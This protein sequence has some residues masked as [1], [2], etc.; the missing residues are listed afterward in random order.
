MPVPEGKLRS[1]FE[2]QLV[3]HQ[4]RILGCLIQLARSQNTRDHIPHP[5]WSNKGLVTGRAI[6]SENLER[7]WPGIGR[8]PSFLIM[9]AQLSRVLGIMNPLAGV[10]HNM[11]ARV[12][13]ACEKLGLDFTLELTQYPGHATELAED[14]LQGDGE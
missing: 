1:A 5:E 4:Y 8:F 11:Q 6:S 9:T 13:E 3:R 12:I 2:S 14:A 7:Y 10:R